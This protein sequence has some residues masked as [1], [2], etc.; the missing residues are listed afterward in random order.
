MAQVD[1]GNSTAVPA[2]T[3]GALYSKTP[4]TPRKP[5]KQ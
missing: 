4:V 3:A 1:S 2:G 5:S